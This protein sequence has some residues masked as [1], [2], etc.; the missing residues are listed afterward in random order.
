MSEQI[1]DQGFDY[2]LKPKESHGVIGGKRYVLRQPSEGAEIAYRNAITSAARPGPDGKPLSYGNINNAEPL[3]VSQCLFELHEQNGETKERPV[4]LT[5][6]NG[7]LSTVVAGL[8]EKLKRMMGKSIKDPDQEVVGLVRK[9]LALEH[10]PDRGGNEDVMRGIN[11]ALDR[12]SQVC[13][14][15]AEAAAEN[16][17]KN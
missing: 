13:K 3:L 11:L 5:Q 2:D 8:F 6:I 12:V 1:E 15:R 7:W 16:E 10:N 4:T 9:E 17:A 14:D